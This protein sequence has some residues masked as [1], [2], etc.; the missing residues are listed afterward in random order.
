MGRQAGSSQLD[1]CARQTERQTDGL[2]RCW[3]FCNSTERA[4]HGVLSFEK[5]Q[6]T[7]SCTHEQTGRLHA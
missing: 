3:S 5:V 7:S 1:T 2:N 6:K 4:E